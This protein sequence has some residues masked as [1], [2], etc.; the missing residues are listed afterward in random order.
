M[1]MFCFYQGVFHQHLLCTNLIKIFNT[2]NIP[3]VCII[4]RIKNF[5]KTLVH[6]VTRKSYTDGS[7]SGMS[8]QAKLIVIMYNSISIHVN[9][10][11]EILYIVLILD[12]LGSL[13]TE[14]QSTMLWPV[15]ILMLCY[16]KILMIVRG[17][18]ALMDHI[19][20]TS[21]RVSNR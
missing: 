1:H 18:Q 16:M 12:L 5:I 4:W 11:Q 15:K 14:W 6:E 19:I 13:R 10:L 21:S 20:I 3:E 7:D 17:T 2:K 8:F 9:G